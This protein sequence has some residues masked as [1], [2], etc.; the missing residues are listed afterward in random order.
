MRMIR[1]QIPMK[2][3]DIHCISPLFLRINSAKS[4]IAVLADNDDIDS[5][6]VIVVVINLNGTT[7]AQ[8]F[9]LAVNEIKNAPRSSN[10]HTKIDY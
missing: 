2:Y 1:I 10:E 4:E 6:P 3:L 9:T 7:Y 5:H 8:P